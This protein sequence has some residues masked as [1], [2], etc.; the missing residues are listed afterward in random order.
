MDLT[1]SDATEFVASISLIFVLALAYGAVHRK[2]TGRIP[3]RL[4]LGILF[5]I[6]AMLEMQRPI[7]PFDGVLID[8]RNIPIALAGAFLGRSG[9]AACLFIAICSRL[10]LGGVGTSAGLAGMLIAGGMGYLW[11]RMTI[12]DG[13][14]PYRAMIQLAAM[15]SLSLFAA[16]FL[17]LTTML[18]FFDEA[19]PPLFILYLLAVPLTALVLERERGLIAREQRMQAAAKSNPENGLLTWPFF[20]RELGCAMTAAPEG[21]ISGLAVINIDNQSWLQRMFGNTDMQ[22]LLGAVRMRLRG[23]F[24]QSDLIGLLRDHRIALPLTQEDVVAEAQTAARIQSVIED[25]CFLLPGGCRSAARVSVKIFAAPSHG[26]MAQLLSNLGSSK[27][28]P[29]KRRMS[30]GSEIKTKTQTLAPPSP[31]HATRQIDQLFDKAALLMA[32]RSP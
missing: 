2:A 7:E 31:G 20:K 22:L 26:E 4:V 6:A 14:R 29:L 24:P 19:A 12:T 28:L 30:E 16:V 1:F 5:G 18:W 9:L 27:S 8:M 21:V 23:A 11:H 10:F 17:P 13:A 3:P 25:D 15:M 32:T